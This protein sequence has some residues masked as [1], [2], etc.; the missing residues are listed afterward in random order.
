MV[1]LHLTV[2]ITTRARK[3]SGRTLASKGRIQIGIGPWGG[4]AVCEGVASVQAG[5]GEQ[6]FGRGY[7]MEVAVV[8]DPGDILP[9]MN[10]GASRRFW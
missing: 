3:R 9:G 2:S 1:I 7:G 6:P 10:A 8:I 5:R 4:E